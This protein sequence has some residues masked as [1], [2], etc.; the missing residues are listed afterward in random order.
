MNTTDITIEIQVQVKGT[1]GTMPVKLSA[2]QD[3]RRRALGIRNEHLVIYRRLVGENYIMSGPS[4][5]G[6]GTKGNKHPTP[7]SHILYDM[8]GERRRAQT[9]NGNPLDLTPE[10]IYFPLRG[11]RVRKSKPKPAK[12][13]E[14]LKGF[15][16][17]ERTTYDLVR[18]EDGEAAEAIEM[19]FHSRHLAEARLGQ[20][21]LKSC[22][23]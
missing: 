11:E 19:G 3:S 10:N 14:T 17:V 20:L 18:T 5:I 2:D 7:L 12:V 4:V 21:V 6:W 13:A 23:G 9:R 22:G 8:T 15:A 16:I 1:P